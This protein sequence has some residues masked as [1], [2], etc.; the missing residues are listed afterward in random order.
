MKMLSYWL[1]D[2]N[3]LD[4][5]AYCAKHSYPLLVHN[6]ATYQLRPVSRVMATIDR[7]VLSPVRRGYMPS[8]IDEYEAVPVK[9]QHGANT[10]ELTVGCLAN[11][12]VTVDDVTV[13]KLHALMTKDARG[14]WYVQDVGST[15]GTHVNDLDTDPTRPLQSGDRIAFGM[16]ELTFH[17][18]ASHYALVRRL[19]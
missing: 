19:I 10:F 6:T 17:L 5:L 7:A 14:F 11:C 9:A 12:D 15:T 1:K 3:A 4:E 13:S 16:V 8:A 18:P 2:A